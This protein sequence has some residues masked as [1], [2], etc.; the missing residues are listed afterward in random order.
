MTPEQTARQINSNSR[1]RWK[2]EPDGSG[3]YK[4]TPRHTA[5]RNFAGAQMNRLTSDWIATGLS[6]TEQLKY[7]LGRLIYRSRDLEINNEY[8]E[9]FLKALERNVVGENGVQLRSQIYEP[10]MKGGWTVDTAAGSAI[11]D[12][13]RDFGKRRN[14][15]ITQ[16]L[17]MPCVQ[18]LLIRSIA[19]DGGVVIRKITGSQ[20]KNPY[21]F[22]LQLLE[23]DHIDHDLNTTAPNGNKIVM[24]VEVD[25]FRRVVAFH[26]LTDHP[27]D[28]W[29]FGGKRYMRVP[30]EQIVHPFVHN[31]IGQIRGYPWA[32]CTMMGLRMLLGYKEAELVA[33]RVGANQGG[34]LKDSAGIGNPYEVED[35]ENGFD[36][37]AVQA[38]EP[39]AAPQYIGNLDFIPYKPE[40]PTTAYGTFMDDSLR[41]IAVGIGMAHH[42]ASGNMAGVNYSS[43]R[44][45]E[46]AERDQWKIIQGWF[47]DMVLQPVFEDWLFSSLA[48]GAIKLPTGQPLPFAKYEKFNQP[49]WRGRRWQW[50]DPAKEVTAQEKLLE[51][52]LT[53]PGRIMTENGVDEEDVYEEI[54][55]SAKLKASKGIQQ[56]QPKKPGGT[57][58][59]ED[60]KNGDD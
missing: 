27:G 59:N 51:L 21:G 16:D 42:N 36:P 49:T 25:G 14:L 18:R 44:I 48:R 43:A 57:V 47:A 40:H 10:D 6:A 1:S 5:Q 53:S 3:S 13:W 4:L 45:A 26:L 7:Q 54:A 52:N 41:G 8:F 2:A 23:I 9:G 29:G 31:R 50:V 39:G 32:A 38:V 55:N 24:G 22:A 12:A 19:R 34:F 46:L 60:T 30:A 17:S 37:Q 28:N 11:D 56:P 58:D 35:D 15:L 33:A 20:V